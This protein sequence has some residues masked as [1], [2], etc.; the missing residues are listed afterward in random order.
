MLR[1]IILGVFMLFFVFSLL[2]VYHQKMPLVKKVDVPLV[3]KHEILSHEQLVLRLSHYFPAASLNIDIPEKD[4]TMLPGYLLLS[5]K[6]SHDGQSV[7]TSYISDCSQDLWDRLED[8]VELPYG[9]TK[10]ERCSWDLRTFL[11]DKN[12]SKE[13][14]FHC[15]ENIPQ[16]HFAAQV[17]AGGWNDI[18]LVLGW[19]PND[20]KIIVD[21][22][23][24]GCVGRE[25]SS[26]AIYDIESQLWTFAPNGTLSDDLGFVLV[27][28]KSDQNIP[29]CEEGQTLGQYLTPNM[30][31]LW[32]IEMGNGKT[33][34]NKD[35]SLYQIMSANWKAKSAQI[36]RFKM[37]NYLVSSNSEEKQCING[38]FDYNINPGSTKN[39][40]S[41]ILT[42]KW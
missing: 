34:L 8:H 4:I 11:I 37:D 29:S 33:L 1:K 39:I 15:D 17:Q 35:K 22:M 19:S 32:D 24:I 38:E 16:W 42:V 20:R 36:K 27:A 21:I 31:A 23:P 9:I 7:V 3:T 14:S 28:T 18:P 10:V 13:I 6:K 12:G 5:A 2:A 26:F 25:E 40:P 41:E 30:V